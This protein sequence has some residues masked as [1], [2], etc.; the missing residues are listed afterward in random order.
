MSYDPI[1]PE[2]LLVQLRGQSDDATTW[3]PLLQ[4]DINTIAQY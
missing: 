1:P 2:A 4:A 3:H